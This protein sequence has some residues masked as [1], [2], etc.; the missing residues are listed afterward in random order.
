MASDFGRADRERTSASG[1]C[2]H[3]TP[4][5]ETAWRWQAKLALGGWCVLDLQLICAG[6]GLVAPIWPRSAQLSG[7]TSATLT[8]QNAVSA[9]SARGPCRREARQDWAQIVRAFR[10]FLARAVPPSS[11]ARACRTRKAASYRKGPPATH[12]RT[13]LPG[14]AGAG[15]CTGHGGACG[16]RTRLTIPGRFMGPCAACD[17]I[18]LQIIMFLSRRRLAKC[19]IMNAAAL[20]A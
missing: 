8:V 5:P 7:P 6:L 13:G 14:V 15:R 9:G 20:P 17:K 11:R 3:L 12:A 16:R 2:R 18:I 1:V 4:P 19:S 10:T